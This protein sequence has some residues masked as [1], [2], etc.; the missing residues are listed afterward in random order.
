[1]DKNCEYCGKLFEKDN[2]LSKKTWNKRKYCSK[3]CSNKGRNN[4]IIRKCVI[5]GKEII[6]TKSR[7]NTHFTCNRSCS[8]IY[9]SKRGMNPMLGKK[10]SQQSINRQSNTRKKLFKEKKLSVWNKGKK[11]PELLRENSSVWKGGI[12]NTSDGYLE[13]YAPK[14]PF[15]GNRVY[16]KQHRL[17]MEEWLRK[18]EPNSEFLV[19]IHGVK[20]LKLGSVVH[21]KDGNKINNNPKNLKC[22]K[23]KGEHLR[24]HAKKVAE[25]NEKIKK[26]PGELTIIPL[27]ADDVLKKDF[28][29]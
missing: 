28:C 21:H 8:A 27:K 13:E 17:V 29:L 26:Y 4:S 5:C 1:M 14:H 9:R 16:I 3:E 7:L 23:N 15:S 22:Y 18:N 2:Y 10:R 25:F 6:V 11:F 20:Y 19:E 24:N 12:V